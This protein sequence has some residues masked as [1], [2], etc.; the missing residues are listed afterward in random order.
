[1]TSNSL[2]S[3]LA[4]PS[5]LRVFLADDHPVLRSGLRYLIAA[6]PDMEVVGEASDGRSAVQNVRELR[7]DVAVIDVSMPVLSGARATEEICRG[8]TT[9]V[10]VLAL[11]ASEDRGCAQQMLA[12]GASGYAI[13]RAADEELVHAIRMVAAGQVYLAP[14]IARTLI[15]DPP[16][17]PNP[18]ESKLSERESAVLKQLARGHAVKRIAADLDV[19][20]RTVETYRARAMTKLGLKTRADIIRHAVQQGWLDES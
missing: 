12:A 5:R 15:H 18:A 8:E 16:A 13:K 19:G 14:T 2:R 9:G 20:A 6:Q 1:M 3:S 10:K 4:T 11:S 17:A 7:P